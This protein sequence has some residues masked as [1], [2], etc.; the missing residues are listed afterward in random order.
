MIIVRDR[1]TVRITV[2]IMVRVMVIVIVLVMV[3]VTV[4]GMAIFMVRVNHN[5]STRVR[6]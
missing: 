3:T 1:Y 2:R 4:R 5:V 6:S